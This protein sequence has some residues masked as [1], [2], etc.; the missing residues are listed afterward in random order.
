MKRFLIAASVIALSAPMPLHAQVA[1]VTAKVVGTCGTMSYVNGSAQPVTQ[2]TTGTLCTASGGGGGGGNV[3]LTGINGVTPSV[4]A[5]ATGTGSLRTTQSQDTTTIAGSAPGTA[6]TP[7][8]N[9][10]T[11]QGVSGGTPQTVNQTQI[12]GV[13]VSVGS[14]TSGTG[15]QRISEAA[16][17]AT[18]T[19]ALAANQ[20]ICG[21][22][23][24]LTSFE[25]MAD[26]TLSGAAWIIQLYNATSAPADGAV[27]PVKCYTMPS[28]T[29]GYTGAFTA[30][31]NFSTGLVIGVSTGSSCY[32]KA[33]STHATFISG[34]SR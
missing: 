13:S 4:G 29:T 33:A 32:T 18:S 9:V 26:S 10:V 27:T 24:Q 34:D 2:D 6:G 21:S 25:V 3:N 28:G 7:S 11:V 17:S 15:T 1:P 14:G 22:A 19:T 8:A 31:V 23:C 16:A 20:V 12:N 30:P 5:G